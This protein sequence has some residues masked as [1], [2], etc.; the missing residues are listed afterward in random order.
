VR[1]EIIKRYLLPPDQRPSINPIINF[2][3]VDALKSEKAFNK[4]K[5]DQLSLTN[6]ALTIVNDPSKFENLDKK[7]QQ[8]VVAFL[9]G[10]CSAASEKRKILPDQLKTALEK[11]FDS[12]DITPLISLVTST[13]EV[14]NDFL[15]K[16]QK[17]KDD[18]ES[19]TFDP[20]KLRTDRLLL[21]ATPTKSE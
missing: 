18:I 17:Q 20:I 6:S 2:L 21:F 12:N 11:V 10:Y 9:V 7:T 3:P 13:P 15:T 14:K 16:Q 19:L 8:S 4:W 1:K 5:E